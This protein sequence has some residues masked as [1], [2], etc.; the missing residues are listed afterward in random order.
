MNA[1]EK[2]FNT[3]LTENGD[4]AYKSSGNGVVDL[5]FLAEYFTKNPNEIPINDVE[6]LPEEARR[7][8]CMFIRDP[9]YG[10][11]YRDYGRILFE[12][13][14]ADVDDVVKAG[15]WDD[16]WDYIDRYQ[17]PFFKGNL[18]QYFKRECESGNELCKK[19]MPRLSSGEVS[20]RRAKDFCNYFNMS[21]KDYSKLIKAN[22]V[23]NTL[24]NGS[25]SDINYE[26]VPSLAMMKYFETFKRKDGERFQKYLDD[27][28]AGKKNV[29]FAT[30]TV[31][32]IYRNLDR[33]EGNAELFFEK[34]PK[35][36]MSSIVIC[37]TSGS[38]F[39]QYD[40]IGKALALTYYFAKNS[41]YAP[42]MFVSFSQHPELI[43]LNGR[44]M[45]EVFE[46]MGRADWGYNTDLGKVFEL[47]MNLEGEMPEYLIVLTDGEFDQMSSTR[48]DEWKR[49]LEKRGQKCK[50][51]WWC[52]NDGRSRTVPELEGDNIFMSG[53]NGTLLRYLEAGFDNEKF[54][55]K[56]LLEYQAATA[57][58]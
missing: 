7:L 33:L 26:H 14:N 34:L 18:Y 39:N 27:V 12:K 30:G 11:G 20:R 2:L 50:I 36:P 53:Y 52:L 38:M 56:L 46:N 35:A 21:H 16:L 5:I 8:L 15:R 24:S 51:C 47:L 49:M 37:D 4:L 41:T 1:L 42:D 13:F 19:W 17:N 6:A 32:D 10:M 54:I 40:A 48:K 25:I 31:Y 44:N 29:N 45:K 9:R 58:A 28:K 57:V 23:E 43:K 22:T 3:K 55:E